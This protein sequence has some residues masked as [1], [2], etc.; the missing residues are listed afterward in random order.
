MML[1]PTRTK[2]EKMPNLMMKKKMHFHID[3]IPVVSKPRRLRGELKLGGIKYLFPSPCALFWC[4]SHAAN[5]VG[6]GM[7]NQHLGT[8]EIKTKLQSL[9][10]WRIPWKAFEV[11]QTEPIQKEEFSIPNLY[12][13]ILS[14]AVSR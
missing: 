14:P 13:T 2:K 3:R 6:Y 7:T 8:E 1:F 12:V 4:W 9:L 11:W 5:M 10:P